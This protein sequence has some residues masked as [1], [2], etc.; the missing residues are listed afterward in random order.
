MTVS[1]D[2]AELT[3]PRD[4]ASYSAARRGGPGVWSLVAFGVLCVLAG[5]AIA[6]FGPSLLPAKPDLGQLADTALHAT[7]PAEPARIEPAAAPPAAPPA[8]AAAEPAGSDEVAALSDRLASLE[9][10]D[11]KITQAAAA[12]LSAAALME[13]SQTSRPF[14]QELAALEAISP[15]S[16]ELSAVRRLAEAG[17]PTRAALAQSFPDYAARAASASHTPGDGAGL[18][19]RIGYALSRVVTLRRV[20]DVA[21]SSVDAVLARAERQVEDG[22]L[23]SALKTLDGLPPA[24]REALADWRARAERRAEID[25]R[26]AAIRAQALADLAGLTRPG[27]KT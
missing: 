9:A 23:D 12:A 11:A 8:P 15:S 21:G 7:E 27:A 13:A 6:T 26:I 22:D 3:A 25:R 2:P 14:L 17:A 19:T 16:S 24:G 5:A 4:P 10:R 20:G 18:L 1:P